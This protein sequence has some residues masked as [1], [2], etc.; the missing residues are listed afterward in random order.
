MGVAQIFDPFYVDAPKEGLPRVGEFFWVPCPETRFQVVEAARSTPEATSTLEVR[1][2]EFSADK[3]FRTK[4]HLPTRLVKDEHQEA[5]L[6][7]A[8]VRPCLVLG[9]ACVDNL[10]TIADGHQ[11]RQSKALGRPLYLV[12]PVY[13]CS[14]ASK[15]TQFTPVITARVRALHY[16]QFAY[17]PDF[18]GHQPGSILRLDNLFPT[19][20]D[21]GIR[22]LGKMLHEDVLMLVKAQATEVLHVGQPGKLREHLLATKDL[23]KDCLPSGLI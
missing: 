15:K 4:E 5:L 13:S 6:Y 12:A 9:R 7:L 8:K 18:H 2:T 11:K 17:M 20:L 21:V 23:I 14:T 10:E 3:H 16:P 1:V 19:A 22:R